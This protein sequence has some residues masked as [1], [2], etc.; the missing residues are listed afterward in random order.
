MSDTELADE[1]AQMLTAVE[2]NYQRE[3]SGPGTRFEGRCLEAVQA[4]A[5]IRRIRDRDEDQ[6][7][8]AACDMAVS[9][10]M[11][12]V[13]QCPFRDETDAGELVITIPGDAPELHDLAAAVDSAAAGRVSHEDFTR[14]VASLLPAGSG[15]VTTWHTGPWSVEVRAVAGDA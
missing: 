12:V 1:V 8:S 11:P 3:T 6:A 5:V 14:R 4:E 15:V 7:D 9:L 2:R 10:R 13:K